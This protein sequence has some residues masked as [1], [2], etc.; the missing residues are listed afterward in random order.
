MATTNELKPEQLRRTVDPRTLEAPTAEEHVPTAGIVGQQRAV[1]ALQFGLGM[2]NSGFNVYVA[3]PPGVGKMTAVQAFV[4]DL[5][6]HAPTP[7]DWCYVNNFDDPYQPRACR[8]PTG[9]GRKF[10][11]DMQELIAHVRREIGRVFESDDYTARYDQIVKE[12][13]DQRQSLFDQVNDHATKEGFA[14]RV[15]PIGIAIIPMTAGRPLNDTEFAALPLAAREEMLARREQL[16]EEINDALKQGRDLERTARDKLQELDRQVA[17]YAVKPLFEELATLYQDLPDIAAY[18][19]A[20]QQDILQHIE[21]FKTSTTSQPD[22]EKAMAEAPGI[23]DVPLRRYQ[24]NVLV[25]NSKREGAPVVVELNPTYANLCGRIEKEAQF[26]TLVTDF[27][28]I[29]AGTL[30]TAAG[31]YLVLEV[32]DLL[33]NPFAWDGLKR[34]LHSREIQIEEISERLGYLTTRSLRP[35]PIPIDVKVILVGSPMVYQLLHAYDSEFAELVKVRADF[36]T[37]MPFNITNARNCLD[38]LASFCQKED[39]L[40]LD[41]SGAARILEHASRLADDQEK[42]STHF[43]ALTDVIREANYWAC[44]AGATQITTAHIR[45]ALEAHV[46]RANRIQERLHELITRGTLQIDT[47][48]R[49]V[50]QING[51]AVIGTGDYAFGQPARITAT[52]GPGRGGVI[53]IEREARLGGP[54]HTK[55]VLILGGYLAQTYASDRP[56]TLLARL[57]FEQS[58]EGIEGDSASSAELYA[59]LSALAKIPIRQDVAVTGAISQMG[60]VQAIGGVNEKIEG[61][62]DVCRARGLSGSQGV[63]IPSSNLPHLMLREDVVAAVAEGRFHI[64]AVT[65]VNEGITLLTGMVAGE[66]GADGRFLEGSINDLVDKRMR[67]FAESLQMHEENRE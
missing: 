39:L 20:V 4:E 25:D 30:H 63:M 55:G 67:A 45:Q 22:A 57:V 58:Y 26:G 7:P 23:K 9:R 31:G 51:L 62:F 46:F 61:F 49:T 59:L 24:V 3:G 42:L 53:D 12:L 35:Q 16:Q 40:P 32:E 21:N 54:I 11:Q 29:K 2:R 19:G 33:S 43:G 6:R 38:V 17:L 34:A 5:A 18:L 41:A 8:L 28:M 48:G 37:D 56:L 50:G 52:V 15:S 36:E 66:R 10:Q 13:N 1:A 65:H 64:W 47:D 44:Q 14:I 27:T 60:E